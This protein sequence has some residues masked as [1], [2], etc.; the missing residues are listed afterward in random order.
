MISSN[1]KVA[2]IKSELQIG[3]RKIKLNFDIEPEIILSI[4]E[5]ICMLHIHLQL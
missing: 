2:I 5:D 3:Q 1:L 4:S